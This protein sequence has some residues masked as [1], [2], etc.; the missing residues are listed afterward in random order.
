MNRSVHRAPHRAPEA[1]AA[2]AGEA[3]GSERFRWTRPWP[4]AAIAIAAAAAYFSGLSD[5]ISLETI[6]RE[7]QALAAEVADNLFLAAVFFVLLY[8]FAVAVS[9]PGATLLTV[10]G[11]FL[12]G[13]TLGAAL[14]VVAA[15]TGASLIF[16]AARTSFGTVLRARAGRFAQKFAEGFEA[17]AFN[18]LLFLRLVPLFPFW[19]V[20]I[21]PALCNVSLATYVSATALGI[22]PGVIAYSLLGDGL[23]GLIE[24]QEA[25]N[26]GCAEAGTCSIDL[27][28]LVTPEIIAAMVALGIAALVPVA[29]KRWRRSR[30]GA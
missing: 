22:F 29:I 18:Y 11:G 27:S 5:F 26:P 7:R 13:V 12:F 20:N 6:I 15:T 21:A 3:P 1:P 14:T 8:A 4:L 2:A 24:A 30:T 17:N 25:A 28:A 16:L 19:V 9:F 10:F 23:G